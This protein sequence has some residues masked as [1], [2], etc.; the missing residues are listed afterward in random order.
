MTYPGPETPHGKRRM[1]EDAEMISN[2]TRWPLGELH[3]KEQPWIKTSDRRF[4][5]IEVEDVLRLHWRVR[6]KDSTEVE[7]FDS[8]LD[9]VEVW[10]VD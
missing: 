7:E 10:S 1:A 9:L 4:G 5:T 2:P 8:I 3:L 6:I